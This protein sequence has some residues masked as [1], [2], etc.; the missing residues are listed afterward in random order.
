VTQKCNR[1]ALPFG[2]VDHEFYNEN[3]FRDGF[4]VSHHFVG[5][6][7]VK[8]ALIGAVFLLSIVTATTQTNRLRGSGYLPFRI[9]AKWAHTY[10]AKP[11]FPLQG[12]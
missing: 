5:G 9:Y 8:G 3:T 10:K 4:P 6:V 1:L 12:R 7:A 2:S 11:A